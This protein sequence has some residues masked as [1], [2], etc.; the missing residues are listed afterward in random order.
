ME[1]TA[2]ELKHAATMLNVASDIYSIEN[3]RTAALDKVLKDI[4]RC[5]FTKIYHSDQTSADGSVISISTANK[6]V[7]EILYREDKNEIGVGG[8]DPTI[9]GSQIFRKGTIQEKVRS[10]FWILS[11]IYSF[12]C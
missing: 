10:V 8:C 12:Q 4:I 2:N 9:Q 6:V 3:E 1:L 5:S 7:V 11:E